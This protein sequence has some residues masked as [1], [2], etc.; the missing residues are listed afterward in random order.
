MAED[1]ALSLVQEERHLEFNQL[2][3]SNGGSVDLSGAHLRAYDLKKFNLKQANL[4]N[5]YMRSADLRGVDL[6][7][8]NLQGASLKEAK[9]SGVSFPLNLEA[10]EIMMSLVHGTRLRPKA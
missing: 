4:T 10:N 8:A 1:R 3:E 5:A 7:A 6:S 2:V 9:V